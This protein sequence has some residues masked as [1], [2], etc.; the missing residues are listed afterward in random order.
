MQL[1]K[2]SLVD[3]YYLEQIRCG[4]Y[5]SIIAPS[6]TIAYTHTFGIVNSPK[7]L[8]ASLLALHR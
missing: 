4:G 8:G 2:C 1:R 7:R 3:L 5:A 6:V